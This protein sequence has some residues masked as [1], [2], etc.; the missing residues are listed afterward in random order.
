MKIGEIIKEYG[1]IGIVLHIL[2]SILFYSGFYFIISRKF[3]DPNILMKKVGI[4][5]SSSDAM[6]VTG[7]A[8]ISY[9]IFKATMPV[10]L[11]LTAIVVPIIARI[12]RK[13]NQTEN[14]IKID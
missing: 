7:D 14:N 2:L 9:F 8:A 12:F 11:Y 4:D 13:K 10:R 3:I 5:T 1:K 6:Q